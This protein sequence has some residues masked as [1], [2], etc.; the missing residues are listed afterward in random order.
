MTI[1]TPKE[2]CVHVSVLRKYNEK[3]LDDDLTKPDFLGAWVCTKCGI[4]RTNE[5]VS[6]EEENKPTS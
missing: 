6:K 1:N 3:R 2:E 5:E 4:S